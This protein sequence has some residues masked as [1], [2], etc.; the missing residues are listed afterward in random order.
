MGG[1]GDF[2]MPEGGEK[3]DTSYC[4]YALVCEGEKRTLPTAFVHWG[5]EFG[6]GGISESEPKEEGIC[7]LLEK[8]TCLTIG[9]RDRDFFVK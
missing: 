9:L 1:G 7:S 3:E 4:P 2:V 5:E 8:C 6:M